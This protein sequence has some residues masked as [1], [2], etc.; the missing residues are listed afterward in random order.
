M[1]LLQL[2]RKK[3]RINNRQKAEP[4]SLTALCFLSIVFCLITLPSCSSTK[5]LSVSPSG[6]VASGNPNE[7]S[8]LEK[9]ATNSGLSGEVKI[10]GSSS[11]FILSEII[12]EAFHKANSGVKVTLNSSNTTEG[13]KKLCAGEI[14]ISNASRPIKPEE[15]ELCKKNNIEFIEL[16]VSADGIVV[17]INSQNKAVAP[18][19]Q[20]KTVAVNPQDKTVVTAP[21]NTAVECLKLE[22][23]KKIWDSSSEGNIKTWDRINPKFT[24]QPITLFAP[25][26]D[27][28]TYSFFSKAILGGEGK[29]RT[30]YTSSQDDNVLVLNVAANQNA[31]GFFSYPYYETNKDK[32]K[33][34]GI[35]SG[36][37]C[38]KPSPDTINDGT[39]Q[40]LS[41]PEFIYVQKE[42]VSRPEVKG[43]VEFILTRNSQK[44]F[45]EFGYIPLPE[46][47]TKEAQQRFAEGKVGSI[48]QSKESQL[49]VN[50]KNLK[51]KEKKHE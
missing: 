3:D 13:F 18:N 51:T 15:I 32:L 40:P 44:F 16:P 38:V 2:G 22:E 5:T 39:Y 41:R 25:D 30:D 27:S 50:I 34:V 10:D 23:L 8:S 31:M 35:D 11:L 43:F 20:A 9:P 46:E 14:D 19:P 6:E 12:G 45:L 33:A 28:G 49:G 17:A 1:K 47:L 37:G 4:T 42:S 21:Q 24:K 48:F 26:K 7:K 29:I 36:K